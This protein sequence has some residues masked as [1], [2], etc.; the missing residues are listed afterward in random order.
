MSSEAY[1]AAGVDLQLGDDLSQ[2]LYEASKLTWEN[3]AGEF[4]E[5]TSSVDAFRGLRDM[6]IEPLMRVPKPEGIRLFQCDDGVGTKVEVAQRMGRHNTIAHDLLAMVVDDA[7]VKGYEPAAVSTTLDVRK[8][9]ESMKPEMEQL[10]EG[11]VEAAK[12]AQVALVNGEVAELGDLVGGFGEGLVYNWSATLLAAG[13]QKRL[14]D[15]RAVRPGD[16]LVGLRERGFRSN[17]LSLVRK[18]LKAAFGENWHEHIEEESGRPWG[19]VVLEPSTIYSPLLVSA[20]GG[21]DLAKTPYARVHGA[22]HITGGGIPAKLGGLLRTASVGAVIEEPWP[23]PHP[24]R[25]LWEMSGIGLEEAH[26]V[27]NMGTGM[28]VATPDPDRI[29][30]LAD[31]HSGVDIEAKRIGTVVAEQSIRISRQAGDLVFEL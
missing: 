18:T 9:T 17:G 22:A 31:Y 21:Y 23:V 29:E 11:Y 1:K 27:W 30:W 10:A 13:H 5:P 26:H 7:A 6:S 24:M 4:G 28:V 2:M 14:L 12:R 15:G 3:R 20:L 8:L 16:A 19:D 25:T